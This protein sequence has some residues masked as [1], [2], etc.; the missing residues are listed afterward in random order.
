[1]PEHPPGLWAVAAYHSPSLRAVAALHSPSLR[2]R[3]CFLPALGLWSS[4]PTAG[5]ERSRTPEVQRFGVA[6]RVPLEDSIRSY[7]QAE[8]EEQPSARDLTGRGSQTN[9]VL[10]LAGPRPGT[11]GLPTPGNFC[12]RL[13]GRGG[14]PNSTSPTSE[15]SL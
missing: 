4:K 14:V 5:R 12:R 8:F 9:S 1:M 13:A 11:T 7:L 15:P 6:E 2:A 3:A 10:W